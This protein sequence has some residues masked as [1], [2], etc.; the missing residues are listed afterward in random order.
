AHSRSLCRLGPPVGVD[1]HVFQAR[2]DHQRDD[3]AAWP[4]TFRHV[5]RG[6]DVGPEEVPTNN[7]FARLAWSL[8]G[9]QEWALFART[10][11]TRQSNA[12]ADVFVAAS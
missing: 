2:V 9:V 8:G 3:L 11:Y 5:Q 7:Q 10:W 4:E 1:I 12:A 6:G